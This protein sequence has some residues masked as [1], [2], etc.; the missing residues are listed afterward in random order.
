MLCIAPPTFTFE[1]R[2]V[3]ELFRFSINFHKLQIIACFRFS[4]VGNIRQ[5]FAASM[6]QNVTRF[7]RLGFSV[8]T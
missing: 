8:A 5:T 2:R 7:M 1:H 6:A 3:A 4:C